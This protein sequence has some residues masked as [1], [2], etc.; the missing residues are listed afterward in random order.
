[1]NA[2]MWATAGAVGLPLVAGL[3]LGLAPMGAAKARRAGLALLALVA[4]S[5]AL[6]LWAGE[7]GA[8]WAVAWL[9]D[10]GP[11]TLELG[12]SGVQAA[13]MTTVAALL[14]LG[15]VAAPR[16]WALATGLLCLGAA[17][18]AYLSGNFLGRYVA[19]EVVALCVAAAP[20]IER[21]DDEGPRIARAV[22]VLL[23][24]GDAGLL[25]AI[26]LLW[27]LSGTLAIDGAL[28]G[29][30][31]ADPASMR[32]V[33]G[34]LALAAWLKM[35]AWPFQAWIE[36]AEPLSPFTRA[37][38][39]ATVLPNLGL[40]L[41]YRVTPLIAARSLT[42][43]WL[44]WSAMLVALA[45]GLGSLLLLRGGAWRRSVVYLC[46]AQA[47]LALVLAAA[48]EGSLLFRMLLLITVPRLALYCAESIRGREGG[49]VC[50]S[51]A[52]GALVMAWAW[53]LWSLRAAAPAWAVAGGLPLLTM[54]GWTAIAMAYPM[55]RTVLAEPIRPRRAREQ[56]ALGAVAG[57]IY[58]WVEQGLLGGLVTVLAG[59]VQW[60]SRTAHDVVE[61]GLLGGFIA[62]LTNGVVRASQVA[63][64]TVEE[65]TLDGS[66][67]LVARGARAASDRMASWHSGKLRSNLL[68]V[69]ISLVALLAWAISG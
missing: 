11:L 29:G 58:R 26:L 63:R 62:A 28:A 46:A 35:G 1:M 57:A 54:A 15:L 22:Y 38:T 8:V 55:E 50:A 14:S 37:W 13:L 52:G 24:L 45:A 42:A 51:V 65:G 56:G 23:R 44:G 60:A 69:A 10:A 48:G 66:L 16:R 34:G 32:W 4:A 5:L 7:P 40:Y 43:Q 12:G 27:R 68:W 19:L 36:A 67:R 47:G 20:L 21:A 9:P 39:F 25:M 2:A 30:L 64:R 53:A 6:A 31:G 18:V 3:G 61:E 59:G 33:V 17:N 49:R 41:L